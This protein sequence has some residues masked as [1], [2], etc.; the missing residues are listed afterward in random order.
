MTHHYECGMEDEDR[1]MAVAGL[2]GF[3]KKLGV[4]IRYVNVDARRYDL[5]LSVE[6]THP[7]S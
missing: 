2:F 6:Y 3:L 1:V 7:E 5:T 4:C